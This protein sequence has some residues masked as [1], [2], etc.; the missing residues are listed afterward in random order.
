[1]WVRNGA[2]AAI[3]SQM[4]ET[5]PQ[6]AW[7]SAV[8][9]KNPQAKR[10]AQI[11]ALTAIAKISPSQALSL[12]KET[13][14]IPASAIF[15]AW[16]KDDPQAALAEAKNIKTME[17]G[18]ILAG[19][20]REWFQ[21]DPEAATAHSLTL[22]PYERRRA[23]NAVGTAWAQKDPKAAGAWI[24]EH[25]QD[26]GSDNLYS[27]SQAMAKQEPA[28]TMAWL[29]EHATGNSRIQGLSSALRTW[30][31]NDIPAAVEWLKGVEDKSEVS[32][33]LG[34]SYWNLAYYAPEEAINL[35]EQI[36]EKH[37]DSWMIGQSIERIADLDVTRALRMADSFTSSSLR[38]ESLKRVL[39]K[40]AQ[41]SPSEALAYAKKLE[42]PGERS[43]LTGAVLSQIANLDPQAALSHLNSLPPGKDT[44]IGTSSIFEGWARKD[45]HEASAEAAKLSDPLLRDAAI[46]AVLDNWWNGG[47]DAV[48]FILSLEPSE[49]T[50]KHIS[51]QASSWAKHEPEEAL[52]KARTLGDDSVAKNF[53]RT[54]I[55]TIAQDDPA[56]AAQALQ[57]GQFPSADPKTYESI[58]SQWAGKDIQAASSWADGLTNPDQQGKANEAIINH[59][60]KNDPQAA[61]DWIGT[62]EKGKARDHAV[63]AY[64]QQLSSVDPAGSLDWALTMGDETRRWD[65]TKSVLKKWHGRDATEAQAWMEQNNL[66]AEQQAEALKED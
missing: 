39:N 15:N 19:I 23:M 30:L 20:H 18:T 33:I 32:R 52:A 1:M 42:D 22:A 43:K 46:G 3:F 34:N 54:V 63:G 41:S 9:I 31:E 6:G 24:A 51:R 2:Y 27:F 8:S 45:P 58:A 28:F 17:R 48:D 5:D 38:Q 26:F 40:W 59:W 47:K 65:T 21:L 53:T 66:T 16:A 29:N 13:T 37:I 25:I 61:A 12:H 57:D 4:A 10:S 7:S 50:E 62:M 35:V 11:A 44:R 56:T 64:T 55:S 49:I 60:A 36:G 14:G